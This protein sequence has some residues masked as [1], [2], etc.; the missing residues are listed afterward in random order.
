M[1]ILEQWLPIVFVALIVEAILFIVLV[2]TGRKA[3]LY[4]M[5]A[6]GV[7]A[8]LL[9]GVERV[10]VT[11]RERVEAAVYGIRDAMKRNDLDGVL[12]LISPQAKDVRNDAR[13][14][15]D[16]LRVEDAIVK[17]NLTIA[18]HPDSTPPLAVAEFNGVIIGGDKHGQVEHYTAPY[19]FV[20][21]FR[22]EGDAWRLRKYELRDP[23][24]KKE[25]P[26]SLP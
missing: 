20:L 16:Q 22:K 13:R 8:V 1:N 5:V 17:S 19:Y 11:E 24:T 2:Q 4:L 25:M 9:V 23:V 6:V 3:V 26:Y 15:F 14:G 10:V 21:T 12:D 18:V 7:L